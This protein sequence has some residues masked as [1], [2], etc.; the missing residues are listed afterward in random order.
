M[1][2]KRRTAA[3][4]CRSSELASRFFDCSTP[5]VRGAISNRWTVHHGSE[6]VLVNERLARQFF[7]KEDPIGRRVRF[8][9][10]PPGRPSTAPGARSSASAPPSGTALRRTSRPDPVVYVPY[11]HEPPSGA[12]VMVRTNFPRG[13]VTTRS[14]ARCKRS[15]GINPCSPSR[16]WKI[17]WRTALAVHSVRRRVRNLRRDCARALFGRAVR[18]HGVFGDPADAGD[19]R[20]DG[21]RRSQRHVSWLFLK[22]GLV[23][24]AIGLTLGLAGAFALSGVPRRARRM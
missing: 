14:G 12:R 24:L 17:S 1:A 22:R 10:V 8:V 11:G 5:L 3:G 6:G 9:Q 20:A 4:R 2:T 13:L 7:A 16:P 15:I 23:Q 19:W 21:G 18:P